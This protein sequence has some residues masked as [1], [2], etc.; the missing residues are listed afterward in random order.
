MGVSTVV[1]RD[2]VTA[3]GQVVEDTFDWYAQDRDGNVWYF[4]EAVRNFVDGRLES[5]DGSFEAGVDGALPGI[6]MP[7][8][9]TPGHAYRQEYYPGQAEDLGQIL[10]ID[11]RETVPV[12]EFE[13]VVVTRDWNPLEPEVVEQKSYAPGI[14]LVAEE[15]V[16]GG[17]GASQLVS[18]TAGGA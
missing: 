13:H 8:D 18:F 3:D 14:G 5:T 9:P 10:H 12:G 1:V 7:A 17:T 2:T 15:T 16:A 6:V 4:G 11:E